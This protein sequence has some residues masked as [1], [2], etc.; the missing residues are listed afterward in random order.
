MKKKIC[1][2]SLLFFII[3]IVSKT[4]IKT[5]FS[6]YESI[7]VIPNFFNLTY[8]MN[9]GAAFSIL[10]GKQ[11]LLIIL[12]IILLIFL[13]YYINKEELNN[14]KVIYYSLLIGG[15]VGNLFDRIIY[16]SVIDFLDFKIFGY[17]YPI[18]N[19]ADSF[20]VIGVILIIIEVIRKDF[21]ENRSKRK[22]K[23]KNR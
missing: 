10:S 1:I 20:I 13:G 12:A 15:I 18:F 21:Y 8:V 14:Y 19:L 2:F 22:W 6:L 16:N 4:I 11:I 5:S 23:F 7:Q 3:D 17:D 9:E